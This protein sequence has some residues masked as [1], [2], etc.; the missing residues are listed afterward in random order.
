[1]WSVA[2]TDT[3][4][5]PGQAVLPVRILAPGARLVIREGQGQS[6]AEE[7][8]LGSGVNIPWDGGVTGGSLTLFDAYGSGIDFVRWGGST[9]VPP[10]GL[11]WTETSAAPSPPA[12]QTLGRSPDGTDS[13]DASDLCLQAPSLGQVNTA[14]Q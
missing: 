5:A 8:Y 4:Y 3:T 1:M 9:Q 7:V 10:A 2:W 13:D 14:C 12:G 11:G 6:S